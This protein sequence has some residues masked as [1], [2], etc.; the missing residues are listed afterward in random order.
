MACYQ[1]PLI[2]F[3]WQDVKIINNLSAQ[4]NLAGKKNDK[5]YTPLLY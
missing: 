2:K 1:S 5:S 3:N 4:L